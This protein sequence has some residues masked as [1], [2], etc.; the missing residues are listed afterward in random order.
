MRAGALLPLKL[1]FKLFTNYVGIAPFQ[2]QTN[3]YRMLAGLKS[4]YHMQGWGTPSPEE[5]LYLLNIKKTPPRAHGGDSFYYLAPC[6]KEKNFFEDVLNKPPNFKTQ[7]FW[8]GAISP[9]LYHSFH[10]ARKFFAN[11]VV[12][13][14]LILL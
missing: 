14:L 13:S 7:F 4:M 6:P 9:C 2:L 3:S 8:T 5:I 12:L 11:L 1:Y 10:R